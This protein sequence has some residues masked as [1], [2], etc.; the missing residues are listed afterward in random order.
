MGARRTGRR[1]ASTVIAFTRI[2]GTSIERKAYHSFSAFSPLP[3][4]WSFTMN[5]HS[6]NELPNRLYNNR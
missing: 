1:S 6:K 3:M 2:G 5:T 4:P